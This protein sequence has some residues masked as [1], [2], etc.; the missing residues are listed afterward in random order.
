MIRKYV[1]DLSHTLKY[2]LL[3]IHEDLTYIEH[4]VRDIRWKEPSPAE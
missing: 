3:Q 2:E 1:L 4:P